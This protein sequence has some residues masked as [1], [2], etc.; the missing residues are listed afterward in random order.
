MSVY[1]IFGALST[2]AELVQIET[3]KDLNALKRVIKEKQIT[4]W[5]SVPTLMEK[6]VNEIN[7]E[8]INSLK[9]ILLSGDWI[10]LS[11][12]DKIKHKFNNAKIVS[13]G[14]ATEAAIWS[15]YYEIEK[16]N[17]QWKSIPYGKPLSNQKNLYLE[18][19]ANTMPN[20]CTG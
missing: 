17:A 18:F 20:R 9:V 3:Q 11:L 13:L 8:Y 16:V 14:G 15:I 5:N 19:S 4:V 7:G 10:P 12:P 1:D 2:G 6:F